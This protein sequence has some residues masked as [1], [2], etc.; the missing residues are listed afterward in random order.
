MTG[1]ITGAISGYSANKAK[2]RGYNKLIDEMQDMQGEIGAKSTGRQNQVTQAYNPFLQSFGENAGTYFDELGNADF[3]QYDVTAPGAFEFDMQA[4]IEQ[5]MNPEIQAILDRGTGQ[6]ESS[7]ASRGTLRS[8]AT[9]KQV[10]RSAA[11]ITAKEY[12][13]AAQRA[14]QERNS[15]YQQFVDAW[16]NELKAQEFNRGNYVSG[17]EAKGKLFDAQSGMFG[18]QQ[19]ELGNIRSAEDAA[20][21]QT[22]G[23]IAQARAGKAGMQS[24]TAAAISGAGQGFKSDMDAASNFISAF[25]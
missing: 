24:N 9:Q 7:A 8:G 23:E 3:S 16:A 15:K 12:D 5:A 19:E 10:A 18:K 6:V 1:T 11:D 14:Q 22:R 13:A 20:W 25:K 2:R 17:L 21:A 4:A